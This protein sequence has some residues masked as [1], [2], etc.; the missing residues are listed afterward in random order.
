[1]G[2]RT[3]LLYSGPFVGWRCWEREGGRAFCAADSCP[4]SY[5]RVRTER[6]LH[7]DAISSYMLRRNPIR[8]DARFDPALRWVRN[9]M[10]VMARLK[11]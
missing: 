4:P 8:D 7:F 11:P 10:A 9:G 5:M 2:S 1:M 3:A 6:T